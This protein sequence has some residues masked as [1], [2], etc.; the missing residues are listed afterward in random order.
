MNTLGIRSILCVGAVLSCISTSLALPPPCFREITVGMSCDYIEANPIPW[1]RAC[2]GP[3]VVTN[4]PVK[5]TVSGSRLGRTLTAG[6]L[7]NCT[8]VWTEDDGSIL[9]LC[10]VGRS[11]THNAEGYFTHGDTCGAILSGSG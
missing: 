7:A 4:D 10:N 3:T 8:V 5:I 2:D 11:Y 1:H 6:Y 9:H